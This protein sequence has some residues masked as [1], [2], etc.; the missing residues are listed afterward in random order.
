[1]SDRGFTAYRS[2]PVGYI[3]S[4]LPLST[5]TLVLLSRILKISARSRMSIS[6]I[7]KAITRIDR[8]LLTPAEAAR[9]PEA[10]YDAA[11]GLF[12]VMA[13]RRPHILME[14]YE[15]ICVHF[16]VLGEGLC[17]PI[18]HPEDSFVDNHRPIH[19]SPQEIPEWARP[20]Q[21]E[22]H[23]EGDIADYPQS[24][25]M[26][27]DSSAETAV[28]AGPI[29][30]ATRPVQVADDVPE[31][32]LDGVAQLGGKLGEL[33]VDGDEGQV[34]GQTPSGFSSRFGPRIARVFGSSGNIFFR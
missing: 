23:S 14:H 15:D 6:G 20:I 19:Y 31:A 3:Q 28:S 22:I 4:T 25:D 7:R 11:T 24:P 33:Q 13:A 21:I 10:A 18:E 34:T 2:D 30:P 9:A 32:A 29:T 1:M 16:P 27:R 5:D 17:G 12:E 8:L 26:S